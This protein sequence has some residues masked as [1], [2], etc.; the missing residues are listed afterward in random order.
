MAFDPLSLKQYRQNF[1]QLIDRVLWDQDLKNAPWWR[2]I[3]VR[4]AQIIFAIGRDIS[5]GQLSLRAMSLVYS[6]VLGFIPTLALVFALLKSLGVHNVMEGALNDLFEILGD[7]REMVVSQIIDFVDNIQVGVIGITSMG[8]LIY[9]VLDMMR[10]IEV[11]FNFI[12][13]VSRGRSWSS[14]VSEYL[15][16][17]IVSPLLIFLSISIT[18]SVNTVFFSDFL[19]RLAFGST[20]VNLIA[21]LFPL[22]FMSLAFAFAYSFLPNTKVRFSSALIGGVVTTIIWKLM[23]AFFGGFLISAARESIYLAF[24]T[25]LALMIFAYIGWLVVLLGSDIAYYHQYPGKARIG[26][27]PV[28]LSISQQEQLT[29]AVAAL[30]IHR[31][32]NRLQ[33]LGQD[34]IARQLGTSPM[35]IERALQHLMGTG[36]LARTGDD[37]PSYLPTGSVEDCTMLEIWRSLR[38]SQAGELHE[39]LDLP[40]YQL[41]SDFL[42]EL[43]QAAAEKLATQRFIDSA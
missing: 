11:S 42:R 26:R 24:A 25:V 18:S 4:S 39:N 2:R 9:L 37:P 1:Q 33:P 41:A 21:F 29:L 6:T 38:D 12:W 7:R 16:A 31:F 22:L 36:L 34:E 8:V 19:E 14:R 17:V 10:K 43:D 20:L 40:E 27:K 5:E 15:F 3:L 35:T 13:G 30:I 32:K 23:G 28:T